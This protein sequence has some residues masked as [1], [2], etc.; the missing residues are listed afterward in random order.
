MQRCIFFLVLPLQCSIIT[1]AESW[2]HVPNNCLTL[3]LLLV[4]PLPHCQQ[5]IWLGFLVVPPCFLKV[6]PS[7]PSWPSTQANFS[8]TGRV[9]QLVINDC[10]QQFNM[11]CAWT[12]SKVSR[13]VNSRTHFVAKWVASH[14]VVFRSIPENSYFLSSLRIKNDKDPPM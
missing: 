7:S 1:M 3:K 8:R 2:Q 9:L 10:C 5:S 12:A 4:R 11:F 14:L 6:T 13:C